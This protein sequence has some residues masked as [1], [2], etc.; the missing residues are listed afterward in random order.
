M[1]ISDTISSK[2][3]KKTFE[4][5]RPCRTEHIEPEMRKLL[6]CSKSYSFPSSHA[7]NHFAIA[8]FLI[9]TLGKSFK[10]SR[11]LLLLWAASIA[12]AQVYV[13]VHFPLDVLL[14]ALMGTL[15]AYIVANAFNHKTEIK[16]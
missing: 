15:V 11:Y 12:Y 2:I 5:P 4:R 13:G 7:F 14:G 6:G 8:V 9:L 16:F 10:Q 3:L 1:T